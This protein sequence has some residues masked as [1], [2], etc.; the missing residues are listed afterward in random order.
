MLVQKI[1]TEVTW[2]LLGIKW[3]TYNF[4]ITGVSVQI[5]RQRFELFS[6]LWCWF[7]L[8]ISLPLILLPL[9]ESENSKA[10]SKSVWRSA[11]CV[12]ADNSLKSGLEERLLWPLCSLGKSY[13]DKF[14]LT[15]YSLLEQSRGC[16]FSVVSALVQWVTFRAASQDPIGEDT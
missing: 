3:H 11:I 15:F 6:C 4:S 12:Q 8:E 1:C 2:D 5:G 10:V 13:E 7:A 16:L 14:S 9:L